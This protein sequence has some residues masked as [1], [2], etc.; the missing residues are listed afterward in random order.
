M[1]AQPNDGRT[2]SEEEESNMKFLTIT[3]AAA[4]LAGITV[5]AAQS[6]QAGKSADELQGS[7]AQERNPNGSPAAR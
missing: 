2:R 7:Q 6:P 1:G 4:L 5:A 3:T